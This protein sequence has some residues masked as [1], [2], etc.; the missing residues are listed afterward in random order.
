MKF[1]LFADLHFQP[2]EVMAISINGDN[3]RLLDAVSVLDQIKQYAI[4]NNIKDIICLGDFFHTRKKIDVEVYNTA[5]S[6]IE[7]YSTNGLNMVL[8]AGNHDIYYRNTAKV[9]SLRPMSKFAKVVN[10]PIVYPFSNI[11]LMLF[12]YYEKAEQLVDLIKSCKYN[13]PV[14]L[15]HAEYKGARRCQFSKDAAKRGIDESVFPLD[16]KLVMM[17][18]YH[19]QQYLTDKIMYLG[20]PLQITTREIFEDKFFYVFDTDTLQLTPVRT[21]TPRFSVV[22]YPSE[23]VLKYYNQNATIEEAIFGNYVEV[24]SFETIKK[25][26]KFSKLLET[27]RNHIITTR[28]KTNKKTTSTDKELN[29][30][31]I[32]DL[33]V[34]YIKDNPHEFLTD[35]FLNSERQEITIEQ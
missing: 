24:V 28:V 14:Y 7:D 21:N 5:Y 4:Q 6:I 31:D 20:S 26:S 22:E 13:N 35:D 29:D 10:E 30:F 2:H 23:K 17:G 12:P 27:A 32:E 33:C 8:L 1:I 11:S 18:H 9:T 19:M 25:A 15:L 34:K 3:S 16:T